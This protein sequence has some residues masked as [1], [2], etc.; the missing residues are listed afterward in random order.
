LE[1]APTYLALALANFELSA[2]TLFSFHLVVCTCRLPLL[3]RPACPTVR[4]EAPDDPQ[5]DKTPA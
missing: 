2:K 5:V 1:D 3:E 4:S